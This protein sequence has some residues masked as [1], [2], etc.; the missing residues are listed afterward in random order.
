M[1][2]EVAKLV[3]QNNCDIFF[4]E[5][6]IIFT[7]LSNK[8][9]NFNNNPLLNNYLNSVRNF[10]ISTQSQKICNKLNLNNINELLLIM[11]QLVSDSDKKT[12][13]V[14]YTPFEIKEYIISEMKISALNQNITI[15]DPSCG[16]GSFLVTIADYL[17]NKFNI[18]FKKIFSDFLYGIDILNHNI[19]KTKVILTILALE[20]GENYTGT[21]NL[22]ISNALSL[23][24]KKSFP[25]IFKNEGFDYIVGNPPYVSLKN[26][27]DE[28]KES[29]NHWETAGYGNTDLYIVFYELAMKLVKPTGIIGY[30]TINSFFTSLN[31]RGLRS[32]ISTR[33]KDFYIY[34]FADK[35]LFQNIQSYT[36]ISIIKPSNN[37]SRITKF[38]SEICYNKKIKT[39]KRRGVTIQLDNQSTSPWILVNKMSTSN[40]NKIQ[41]FDRKL[42]NCVI[43]N[44]IATLKNDVYFFTP[45]KENEL[46]YFFSKD[47]IEYQVEKSICRNIV[48]PNIIKNESE[49]ITKLEKAI[50][51]Y[52]YVE[53]NDIA[54]YTELELKALFPFAYHYL[55]KQKKDLISR[56][57]GNIKKYEQWFAYGRRQ[58]L[59]THGVK[60]FIP[61]IAKHPFAV[62]SDDHDLLYYC[63]NAIFVNDI[64]EAMF[65]KKI[66]ESSVFDYYIYKTSKP[67]SSGFYSLSKAYIK[68]FSI[69][70]FTSEEISIFVSA[71]QEC[72]NQMLIKKYNIKI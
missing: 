66:I 52:K 36:C 4:T 6:Q 51:P 25:N 69:P 7:Y 71:T 13:G 32:L 31:A 65:Y 9:I 10:E 18:S 15:C 48:K 59:N 55:L 47:K 72:A 12:N 49:L 22:M 44:G 63:G 56:D 68:N 2:T 3:K 23:D 21:F 64:D 70:N 28:V 50:F 39:D 14:V 19:E 34:N 11:E 54:C 45:V 26:M 16:C 30:I 8:Q 53:N 29:L 37:G 35:Q 60:V 57:K 17:H 41:R 33:N 61:Y 62:I 42:S 5:K 1:L 24:W 27:S 58:G 20:Y 43:K 38:E 67:Y 40:I 46:Y